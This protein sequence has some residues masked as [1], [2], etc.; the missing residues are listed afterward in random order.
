MSQVSEEKVD[1]IKEI[2]KHIFIQPEDDEHWIRIVG[3]KNGEEVSIDPFPNLMFEDNDKL[4]NS[5]GAIYSNWDYMHGR[6]DDILSRKSPE[7]KIKI[8]R[9]ILDIFD[10]VYVVKN[11]YVIKLVKD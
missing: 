6:N 1:E 9:S 7:R 8:K 5:T 2:N 3:K 4:M 10:S 11:L